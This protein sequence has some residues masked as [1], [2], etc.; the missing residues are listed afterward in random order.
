MNL[1]VYCDIIIGNYLSQFLCLSHLDRNLFDYRLYIYRVLTKAAVSR[2]SASSVFIF[3]V[4][5]LK[6][7][8]VPFQD[9]GV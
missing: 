7:Q 8:S 4:L 2:L 6:G 1:Q 9:D 3:R 5:Y